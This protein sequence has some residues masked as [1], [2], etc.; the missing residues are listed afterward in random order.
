MNTTFY[1]IIAV[2]VGL[3]IFLAYINYNILRKV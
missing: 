3:L 1:I 2:L